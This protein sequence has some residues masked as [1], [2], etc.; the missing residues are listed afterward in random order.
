ME[1]VIKLAILA[2]IAVVIS[3]IGYTWATGRNPV[4]GEKKK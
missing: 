3:V 4:K 2:V 1:L